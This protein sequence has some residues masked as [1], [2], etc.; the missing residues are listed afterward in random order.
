MTLITR[1]TVADSGATRTGAAR[2]GP[3]GAGA[4]RAGGDS[5]AKQTRHRAGPGRFG[6]LL[7]AL[8]VTYLLSAFFSGGWLLA[9]RVGLFGLIAVLALRTAPLSRRLRQLIL[10]GLATGTAVMIALGTAQP[11]GTGAGVASLW[12]GFILLGAV[13]VIV[14]RVLSYR[15]VTIQSI[16]AALSA[17]LILGMMFASF[18]A[19]MNRLGGTP[20]FAHGQPVNTQ[21]LQYFSFTT[22]TT[23]GYGDF[24]AAASAGRAVAV[25]EAL[26]GQIFL[27][28]LVASLVAGFRGSA[29]DP[30]PPK[31]SEGDKHETGG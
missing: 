30:A 11:A 4:T 18:F 26:T 22:L 25:V 19:A 24:T 9:L 15:G 20:F 12:A 28:T 1:G 7:I 14:H 5:A 21:T 8:L 13:A 31:S 23:L 29:T 27:V 2:P 10:A 16:Y 6:I 17:Y 3:A